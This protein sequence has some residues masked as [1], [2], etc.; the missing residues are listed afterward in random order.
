MTFKSA[1]QDL[2]EGTLAA[3]S[4]LLSKLTYFASLRRR[5]GGYEHWGLSSVHGE[6]PSQRALE[7]AHAEVLSTVLR[8]PLSELQQD[9][10]ESS[11]KNSISQRDY[12]EGMR[13]Q[14]NDLVPAG[15]DTP[16]ARHL[17]SVLVALSSL[18]KTRR[19]ATRSTS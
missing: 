15:Q 4:G 16:E 8:T 14:I 17:S 2:R 7:T 12:L 13:K 19:R 5:G 11:Q 1:L 18:E 10:R 3:V 6:E 9:L